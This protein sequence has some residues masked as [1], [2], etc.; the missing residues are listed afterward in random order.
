MA[1]ALRR[2]RS[3][4][5]PGGTGAAHALMSDLASGMHLYSTQVQQRDEFARQAGAVARLRAHPALVWARRIRDR[6]WARILSW[7]VR[8]VAPGKLRRLLGP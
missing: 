6:R 3:A 7:P 1:L 4:P 5:A 2:I 8:R